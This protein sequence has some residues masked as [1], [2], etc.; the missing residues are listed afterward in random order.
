MPTR[1]RI[2]A[3]AALAVTGLGALAATTYGDPSG[4]N[5]TPLALATLDGP[6][7]L[8]NAGIEMHMRAARDALTARLEFAAHGTTGWH[9]HPGPVIVQVASGTLTLTRSGRHGCVSETFGPGSGFIEQGDLVHQASAGDEPVVVY[10]T[11]LARP[12]TTQ[13]LTPVAAPAGC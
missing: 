10:A 7:R 13:Y 3:L 12:G 5:V 9:T 4:L 11:F 2:A 6:V 1:R 8:D